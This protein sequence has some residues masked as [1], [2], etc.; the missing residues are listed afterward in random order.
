M[1]SDKSAALVEA[2]PVCEWTAP[3]AIPKWMG[4][5]RVNTDGMEEKVHR[6]PL[7]STREALEIPLGQSAVMPSG[8]P[9]DIPYS[10]HPLRIP[11]EYPW[12]A[13]S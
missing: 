9:A 3:A 4:L 1:L 13:H 11:P 6:H 5:A 8:H 2:G 12:S 10:A 7:Q